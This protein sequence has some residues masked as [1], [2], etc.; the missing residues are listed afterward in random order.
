LI[1]TICADETSV[2][3]Y[4]DEKKLQNIEAQDNIIYSVKSRYSN[5]S[6]SDSDIGRMLMFDRSYQGGNINYISFKGGM[7][8]TRYYHL[9][10]IFNTDIRNILILGIGSGSVIK[11]ST[12]IYDYREIDAI[13]IDSEVVD[14]AQTYF[15]LPQNN[16]INYIVEDAGSYILRTDKKYDLVI[17]DLFLA[18]GMPLNFLTEEFA[19]KLSDILTDNGIVGI[20]L[21]GNEDISGDQSIIFRSQY[22]VYNNIFPFVACFPVI[23]GAY[24]FYRLACNLRYKLG[25]LTNIVLLAARKPHD[26]NN[27]HF[28]SRAKKLQQ[29]SKFNYFKNYSL[30]ARDIYTQKI[31]TDDI[32]PIKDSFLKIKD[33]TTKKLTG[34]IKN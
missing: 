29:H 30:Y 17:V 31:N 9:A 4:K 26:F 25:N 10:G 12:M 2:L 15:E 19:Q 3:N 8:Y 20:N 34:L 18:K 7:P 21:F 32:K 27:N 14:I 6:I 5:I 22:K 33:L 1:I 28:I 24:E 11:D 16:R 13:D 23:Y